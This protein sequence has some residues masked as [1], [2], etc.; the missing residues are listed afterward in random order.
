MNLKEIRERFVRHSG[1]FDLV[2]DTEDFKDDGANFFINAGQRFL[3]QLAENPKTQ[4][5]HTDTLE[6][7]QTTIRVP[8]LRSADKVYIIVDGE[9]KFLDRIY[10]QDFKESYGENVDKA[11]PRFYALVELRNAQRPNKGALKHKGIVIAPYPDEEYQIVIH[12]K[13]FSNNLNDD[14]D[15]SYWSMEYPET[16]I[17]AALYELEKFYRNTQGMND[18]LNA[19][20]TTIN[21]VDN[22]VVEEEVESRTTM[23][24][25]FNE[26]GRI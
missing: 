17:Q 18:H 2:K 8:R 13:Y 6:V 19:I 20:M 12:G 5:V 10:Y 23:N 14:Q 1:R 21:N 24:D 4:A 26:R 11:E 16:L 9:N 7:G 25:S 15:Y 22:D 3:D